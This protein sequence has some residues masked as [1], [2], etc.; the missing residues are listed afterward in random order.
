MKTKIY[1]DDLR[2]PTNDNWIVVRDYY[3]FV[4]KVKELGLF[5]FIDEQEKRNLK[6]HE[7][8]VKEKTKIT[9]KNSIIDLFILM[10][11]VVS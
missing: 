6:S 3:E 1:L 4:E 2:T 9:K 7:D 11:Q 8:A 5:A 10:E